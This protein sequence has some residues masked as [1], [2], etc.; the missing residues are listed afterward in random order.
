M[1]YLLCLMSL[2]A[3]LV[4][5]VEAAKRPKALTQ[6]HHG[7][8]SATPSVSYALGWDYTATPAPDS[9]TIWRCQANATT[10]T[11]TPS[12][13][14]PGM[15]ITDSTLRQYR[16]ETPLAGV[17]YCWTVTGSK[18]GWDPSPPAKTPAGV[19]YICAQMGGMMPKAGVIQIQLVG[20]ALRITWNA[21]KFDATTVPASALTGYVVWI[22]NTATTNKWEQIATV[23]PTVLTW[24]Y[25]APPVGQTC[26]QIGAQYGT[27]GRVDNDTVCGT[28][29]PPTL[30]GP[31]N[32]REV[33]ATTP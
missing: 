24:N 29:P 14:L 9:W 12:T 26:V 11:C 22:S 1:Q 33:V 31:T 21:P 18:A 27:L 17:P 20:R 23:S 30:P 28:V 16:D 10:K 2:L 32:L 15:P 7:A 25:A 4:S 8:V 5:Q 19:P 13:A 3:L 6:P